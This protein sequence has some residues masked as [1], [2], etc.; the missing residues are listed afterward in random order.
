[1]EIKNMNLSMWNPINNERI[2]ALDRNGNSQ[3]MEDLQYVQ[4][5]QKSFRVF[6]PSRAV[7]ERLNRDESS[8]TISSPSEVV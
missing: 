5:E 7:H 6:K 1:M 2:P 3:K 8:E 4:I